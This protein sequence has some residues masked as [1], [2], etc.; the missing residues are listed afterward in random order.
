MSDTI[1]ATRLLRY[2]WDL[3]LRPADDPDYDGL[4]RRYDED[5]GFA[6]MV[7]DAAMGLGIDI[8]ETNAAG[9]MEA[10]GPESPLLWSRRDFDRRLG[11]SAET[12]L[13]HGLTLLG[14]AARAFPSEY[15]LSERGQREVTVEGVERLLTEHCDRL[16]AERGENDVRAD[17]PGLEEAWRLWLRL[18]ISGNQRNGA[19]TRQGVVTRCLRLLVELGLLRESTRRRGVFTTTE[20]YRVQVRDLAGSHA[21]SLLTDAIVAPHGDGDAGER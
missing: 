6:T 19:N 10:P 1:L 16:H 12:R 11:A 3:R 18:P 13:L 14:I 8:L 20:R 7:R 15:E 21:Y 5:P 17:Q 2:G 4:L 9:I